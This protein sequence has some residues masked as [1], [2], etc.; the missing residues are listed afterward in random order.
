MSCSSRPIAARPATRERRHDCQAHCRQGAGPRCVFG[1]PFLG[2]VEFQGFCLQ[3]LSQPSPEVIRCSTFIW[4][5]VSRRE[6]LRV[7]AVGTLGL[8]LPGLLRAES[9]NTRDGHKARAKS[10]ILVYLGGGLSHHDSFD[11]KP[12][13]PAEIR[14]KY[15][16]IA[17]NVPGVQ[18]GELL[19][20]LGRTM[21]KIALVRPGRTITTTTRRQPTGSCSGRFGSAFG[22]YPA[23]GAV[24]SHQLGFRGTLPPYVAIPRNPSFTWELGK[25]ASSAAVTNRSRPVIR[26]PRDSTSQ[27]VSRADADDRRPH[28][29]AGRNCSS[30]VDGLARKVEGNDQIA[31]YDEFRQRAPSMILSRRGPQGVRHRARKRPSARPLW[32]DDVRPELLL[33]RGSIEGGVRFVTINFGGW[34]HHA[35]IWKGLESKLPDFDRGL[36]RSDR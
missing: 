23:V 15:M 35:Q 36:F 28:P 9:R 10:V 8:T 18:I 20:H 30:A 17:T 22:D 32:P 7:G 27:D 34:D 26:M 14:G 33:A 13:A 6:F 25:S 3:S 16:P 11:H 21:D 29:S 4:W 19:P 12:D 5:A 24:V 1:G 2:A 31:T